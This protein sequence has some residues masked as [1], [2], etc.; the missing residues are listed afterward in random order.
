[1]IA[2]LSLFHV[3]AASSN[4]FS[5]RPASRHPE[6]QCLPIKSAS[7]CN[8]CEVRVRLCF[9]VKILN[10]SGLRVAGGRRIGRIV[11]TRGC[12]TLLRIGWTGVPKAGEDEGSAFAAMASPPGLKK[13]AAGLSLE[14][15]RLSIVTVAQCQPLFWGLSEI[16]YVG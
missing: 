9:F 5:A 10:A 1:M 4:T 11:G 15:M 3:L 7:D 8:A 12:G 6:P 16:R 2:P 13:A 14:L